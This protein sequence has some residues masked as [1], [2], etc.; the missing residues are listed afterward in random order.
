MFSV[1]LCV[2]SRIALMLSVL[3]HVIS[4]LATTSSNTTVA[5]AAAGAGAPP[6]VLELQHLVNPAGKAFWA[7]PVARVPL[8]T[9]L[10]SGTSSAS[11]FPD[12]SWRALVMSATSP[13][14]ERF[15]GWRFEETV[16]GAGAVRAWPST[17]DLLVYSVLSPC[18]GDSVDVFSTAVLADAPV[19]LTVQL[20][21]T[22]RKP[23][24][25][26]Q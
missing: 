3:T 10:G 15:V 16:P 5:D 1:T 23:N 11:W 22:S 19:S 12:F 8:L 26:A 13:S 18:G 4:P 7:L 14:C 25:N 6:L 17:F 21:E 20:N 24:A 2:C 9:A